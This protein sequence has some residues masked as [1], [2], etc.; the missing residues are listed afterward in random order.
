MVAMLA[1]LTDTDGRGG[2]FSSSSL[3]RWNRNRIISH[4]LFFNY[5]KTCNGNEFFQFSNSEVL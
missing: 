5:L 3:L 4:D 1:V 2:H